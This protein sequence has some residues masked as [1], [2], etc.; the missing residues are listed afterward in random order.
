MANKITCTCGHSWNTSDSSKKDATVCHICGKNN[1]MKMQNGGTVKNDGKSSDTNYKFSKS[2]IEGVGTFAKNNIQPGDYI[3]KVHTIHELGKDYD[4]TS[5]GNNH[6]HSDNPN[7]QNVLIGNERHLVAI[8]PI[9][10]G[11]ELTSN[12]RLQPDLEQP[13]GFGKKNKKKKNGGWLDKYGL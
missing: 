4:F 12:Y 13:E 11:E 6:N 9:S 3:G 8:K 5:L 1:A 10:K 2:K 7:V